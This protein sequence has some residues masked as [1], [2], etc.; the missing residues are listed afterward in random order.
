MTARVG[1]ILTWLKSTPVSKEMLLRS[2]HTAGTVHWARSA[3]KFVVMIFREVCRA[4]PDASRVALVL[5]MLLRTSRVMLNPEGREERG[6]MV[7]TL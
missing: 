7:P 6:G 2:P 3:V 5:E 1:F 4:I